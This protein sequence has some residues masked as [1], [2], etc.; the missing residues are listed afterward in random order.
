MAK[1][2]TSKDLWPSERYIGG[3][4]RLILSAVQLLLAALVVLG[5]LD[6]LYLMVRGAHAEMLSIGSVDALQNA[7]QHG[8]SGVLL[9]LIGLELLETVRAYLKHHRVR[10]EVVLIVAVVALGR[11]IVEL[12]LETLDGFTLIGIAALMLAL[13]GGYFLVRVRNSGLRP[14]TGRS[15]IPPERTD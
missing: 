12:D 5:L 1:N 15:D 2:E 6:L 13:T 8:F 10:L 4:E 11:H 7:M 14:P 9:V 3:F